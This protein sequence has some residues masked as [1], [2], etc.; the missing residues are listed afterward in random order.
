MVH[1]PDFAL[2]LVLGSTILSV[3]TRSG[4]CVCCQNT[5]E[6]FH[7]HPPWVTR[8]AHPGNQKNSGALPASPKKEL[9]CCRQSGEGTGAWPLRPSRV[10]SPRPSPAPVRRRDGR[11]GR[12]PSPRAHPWMMGS[13]V[14]SPTPMGTP[15]L[16]AL[17]QFF[18]SPEVCAMEG[19][20]SNM[21]AWG[22]EPKTLSISVLGTVT[23]GQTHDH[24][25][26]W[27]LGPPAAQPF[28]A[29]QVSLFMPPKSQS[30]PPPH[31]ETRTP[32]ELSPVWSPRAPQSGDI[33]LRFV[34]QLLSLG[35]TGKLRSTVSK[36]VG[37]NVG[38]HWDFI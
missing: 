17:L 7:S 38:L 24:L 18:L 2:W 20:A 25:V 19:E 32:G 15:L 36:E 5:A 28:P 26:S 9:K 11:G 12:R 22:L 33:W 34:R 31:K 27:K 4:S 14:H 16:T 23:E 37:K 13:W 8:G 30:P 3:P 10:A 29:F 35:S 1:T 21:Q 6:W